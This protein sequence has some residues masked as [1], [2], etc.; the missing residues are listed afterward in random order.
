[1]TYFDKHDVSRVFDVTV[2]GE[3]VTWRRD[4]PTFAQSASIT[5]EDDGDR[6][7]SKGRMSKS[8]GPWSDDLSQVSAFHPGLPS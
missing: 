3:T 1:M 4:D 6:L 7:V 5:P 8:G 2:D